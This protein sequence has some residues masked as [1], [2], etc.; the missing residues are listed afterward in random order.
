MIQALVHEIKWLVY[1]R[2]IFTFDGFHKIVILNECHVDIDIDTKEVHFY[3]L[4]AMLTYPLSYV[5]P[6]ARSQQGVIA[7]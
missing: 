2:T 3:R 5:E 7:N 4:D 1:V 6:P